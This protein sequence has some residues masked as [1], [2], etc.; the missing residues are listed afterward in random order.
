MSRVAVD[1]GTG[2]TVLARFNETAAQAETLSIPGITSEMRYRLNPGEPERIAHVAPS[3]IHYSDTETLI[4]DQVVSRG[5][6]EHRHT[7]RW[8]KRGIAQ[9]VTRRRKTPQGFKSPAE[10][11]EEFLTLLLNYVGDRLDFERDEFTFTAPVEAFEDFQ[12]WLW[13]VCENVGI[14]RARMLDEPTACVLGYQGAVRRDDRFLVFDFGC[15]TLDVAAVR[16]EPGSTED[17]KA[18]QLGQAGCR[19]GGMDIDAWIAEDFCKRHGLDERERRDVEAVALRRAEEAKIALSDP[20]TE[21]AEVSVLSDAS[22]STRLLR[23]E[24]TRCCS[25]C[26]KGKP[27]QNGDPGH[28][29]LGCMLLAN[30]FV[31]QVRETV[32]RALEN[33]A[34]HANMRR[35]DVERVVV[36]GGTGLCVCVREL[37]ESS[38]DGKVD[39]ERPF[40]AVA[41]GACGG[42]EVGAILQHDYAIES[43]NR[44]RKEFEFRPLF[45]SGTEYPTG[46]A[47]VRLWAKG[48]YDGQTRIGLK[49]FEVSRMKRRRLDVSMVDADGALRDTSRVS[50]EYEYICLNS[51]N[52]TFIHAD[53]PCDMGRDKRR[54]LCEFQVDGNRRL[55]VTA[56]DQLAQKVLLKDHPVVRL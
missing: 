33:A 26:L 30:D 27:G 48:A 11:G 24:Y 47:A 54:F 1:F 38:F 8:M 32:E 39:Y 40:D 15:G 7:V 25:D 29:C 42:Q 14:G 21:D 10:A 4:A 43:Y 55:L 45:Q 3:V 56:T 52:P 5:L 50:S 49:I 44:E 46:P 20:D 2:N 19:L 35:G 23:T 34:V 22:G 6:A 41:R 36:T 17:K 31:K 13:R 18:V 16:I 37:L 51:E 28:G 12:D 9:G 53:P